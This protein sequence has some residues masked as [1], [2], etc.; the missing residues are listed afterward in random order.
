MAETIPGV[1]AAE[2]AALERQADARPLDQGRDDVIAQ[3]MIQRPTG[4]TAPMPAMGPKPGPQP[5]PPPTTPYPK[6]ALETLVEQAVAARFDDLQ[7]D[8]TDLKRW[9]RHT[10]HLCMALG[11]VLRVSPD[12]LQEAKR[13]VDA[14][15]Q[16]IRKEPI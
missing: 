2:V 9:L 11:N 12:E 1:D 5:N 16:Q 8:L 3:R 4:G 13:M 15:D 10:M 6:G 7:R 14:A